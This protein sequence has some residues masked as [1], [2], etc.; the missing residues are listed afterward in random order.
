MLDKG[1]LARMAVSTLNSITK[2]Y[3]LSR[4]QIINNIVGN[5]EI[6]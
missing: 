3:Y 5:M 4:L 2:Q 1:L 6:C